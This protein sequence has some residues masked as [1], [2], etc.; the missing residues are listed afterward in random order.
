VLFAW[1]EWLARRRDAP[2]CLAAFHNNN[3]F[4]LMVLAGVILEYASRR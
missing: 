2:G 3:F 1:Q 4:G